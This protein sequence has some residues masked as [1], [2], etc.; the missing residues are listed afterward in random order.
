MTKITKAQA[1]KRLNEARSKIMRS[2]WMPADSISV[3]DTSA[4]FKM[5]NDLKKIIGR[6]K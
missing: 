6:I 5:I 4:L 3:K 1:K 2:L